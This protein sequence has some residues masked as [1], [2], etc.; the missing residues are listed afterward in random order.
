MQPTRSPI[1]E[2]VRA[3]ELGS[4]YVVPNSP[5]LGPRI[6]S[7]LHTCLPTVRWLRASR[8]ISAR[9]KDAFAL[10]EQRESLPLRWTPQA[11]RY[12][13]NRLSET[14]VHDETLRRVRELKTLELGEVRALFRS[15][16]VLPRLD[17]HQI[18]N[19]AAM[20]VPGS[21]GLC[22][23]DEQGAGKTVT[24]IAT[25]DELSSR[26]ELD[27]MLIVAPKSM[28]GE[29]PNDFRT[30]TKDLYR[31]QV[32]TGSSAD[33]RSALRA[34]ADVLITNYETAVSHEQELEAL[35]RSH[36]GRSAIVIDESFFIKSKD[37]LRTLAL[38]RLREWCG[39]AYVLCGTPAP[40]RP[41]DLIEQFGFVDFGTTFEGFG[42]TSKQNADCSIKEVQDAVDARGLFLRNLKS[43]V[44]P[45]LP[46]KTFRPVAVPLAT[47]QA[48]LYE[49]A[50]KSLVD[51]LAQTSDTEFRRTITNYLSRRAALLQICSTP[52]SIAVEYDE[53]PAKLLALD[54]LLRRLVLEQGE[55]VVVWSFFTDS[56]TDMTARYAD[57]G[58]ARY[59]GTV[60][61]VDERRDAVRR[62]Q[63]DDS[64][65]LF[66]ANPAA[67][68]A[69]L[70]LHRAR[71]AIYESMSNQAAHYLQSLDRIHRRGQ[72]RAVEYFVLLG[73]GTIDETEYDRL[74]RKEAAAQTLLGDPPSAPLERA[75]MLDEAVSL[76]ER[77]S[78]TREA[79]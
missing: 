33:K 54:Q 28:V 53:T 65:R 8:G 37:A 13:N 18:R 45:D 3:P 75:V 43:Q 56:I 20:T 19:V 62:F 50:L 7:L 30:F 70:T 42:R 34:G 5:E 31:V 52:R 40:N 11:V 6:A 14:A 15:D 16:V 21:P 38:K 17:E 12:V 39:R 57:Y 46:G 74:L 1:G 2:V 27:F 35:L 69:G 47:R 76:L 78:Q 63:K 29:W 4:L 71:I 32:V 26:D 67:A 24:T 41:E 73:S 49:Q 22:L 72:D 61:S 23:F 59:D 25:F 44:L 9:G 36:E 58:V 48:A 66:I 64:T 51:D 55:K 10:W 68:G 60:S 77:L 79:A